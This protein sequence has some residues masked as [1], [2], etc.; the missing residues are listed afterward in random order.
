MRDSPVKVFL[1]A[2]ILIGL[3]ILSLFQ[4]YQ[5]DR[6]YAKLNQSQALLEEHLEAIRKTLAKGV[7]AVPTAPVA[8]STPVAP[9]DPLAKY[10]DPKAVDGDW[11]IRHSLSDPQHLNPL[12]SSDAFVSELEGHIREGLA[13]R[14]LMDPDKWI[15]VLA[16]AWKT[17]QVSTFFLR[18]GAFANAQAAAEALM[19]QLDKQSRRE[20]KIV[21][22]APGVRD[23]VEVRLGEI[24][25]RAVPRIVEILGKKNVEPVTKV[26]LA[27]FEDKEAPKEK[28]VDAAVLLRRLQEDQTVPEALRARLLADDCDVAASNRLVLKFRGAPRSFEFELRKFILQPQKE[29]K[30]RVAGQL[31]RIEKK[32]EMRSLTNISYTFTLRQGV[33]W[34]DGTP[35]ALGDFLFAWKTLRNPGVACGSIRNYYRDVKKVRRVD[36]KTIEFLWK[37]KYFLAFEFSAGFNPVPE[38]IYR[39]TDPQEFNRS[40]HNRVSWGTG[41]YR[42]LHWIP[43]Q[44]IA[45]VRNPDYWGKKPHIDRIVW[46]NINDQS[47]ALQSLRAGDIDVLGLTK[48]QYNTLKNNE[49]FNKRFNIFI[50]TSRSYSYLGW[51]MRNPLFKDP[52]VRRALTMLTPRERMLKEVYHGLA[53]IT[54]GNFW[55]ESASCDKSV[56]RWPFNPERARA[57]L[58]QAGWRDTDGD[59]ILDNGGK[60]LAFKLLI[61]SG[62]QERK[63]MAAYTQ[64]EFRKAG[65]RMKIDSMEWSVFLDRLEDLRFDAVLLGWALGWEGDPYQLWHSSQIHEHESNHCGFV[66]READRLIE[67]AREELDL[68]KRLALFHRF[69]RLL[70]EEQPY[71]FLFT[72]KSTYAVT[73]RFRNAKRY[74]LGFD[75]DGWYVPKKEQKHPVR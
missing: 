60:P 56:E 70:H 9:V 29:T 3:L 59:G 67:M 28:R 65:I 13:R 42:F 11:L 1:F 52:R 6:L 4:F 30:E 5:N 27:V 69:H 16:T 17:E 73:R 33:K 12:T 22:V 62:N 66:N 44:E 50:Y 32:T 43:N 31:A 35:L 37:K 75:Y 23:A 47:V 51:N 26:E 8:T 15:P 20:L 61:N 7:P 55:I 49:E 19:R 54:T 24:S 14:D 63:R 10:R 74:R 71:T 21:S 57:L 38:H 68:K 72:T 36:E 58:A 45:I 25:D 34:H 46:K 48:S 2:L 41:P 40:K 53:T 39:F 18:P 64:E